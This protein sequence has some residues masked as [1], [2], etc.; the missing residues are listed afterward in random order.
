MKTAPESEAAASEHHNRE[1]QM[2]TEIVVATIRVVHG[3]GRQDG[4]VYVET[5]RAI[6]EALRCM[7]ADFG[8]NREIDEG[9]LVN[10]VL[11]V[12]EQLQGQS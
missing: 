6:H 12:D 2:L 4:R 10:V 11:S 8:D 3:P 1:L 7:I 9:D 5:I